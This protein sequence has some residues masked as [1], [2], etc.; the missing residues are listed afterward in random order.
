[1]PSDY[2]KPVWRLWGRIKDGPFILLD[3]GTMAGC[4]RSRAIRNQ[5]PLHTDLVIRHESSG[6]PTDAEKIGH[7]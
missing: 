4:E 2:R 3:R 6:R 7:R 5:S 1:M